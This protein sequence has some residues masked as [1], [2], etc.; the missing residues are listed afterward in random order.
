MKTYLPA[1][2][3]VI[4]NLTSLA[5]N[6]S[7]VNIKCEWLSPSNNSPTSFKFYQGTPAII[8]AKRS[9][10]KLFL[11]GKQNK[12]TKIIQ[13]GNGT[14]KDRAF[15]LT[16]PSSG[17]QFHSPAIPGDTEIII[18]YLHNNQK[19]QTKIFCVVPYIAK[20][21]KLSSDI[22]TVQGFALGFYPNYKTSKVS[23]IRNNPLHYTA[24]KL[25]V[26]ITPKNQDCFISPSMQMKNMVI[27]GDND[28]KRHTDFFPANM[29]FIQEI[30]NMFALFQ[31]QGLPMNGLKI[32]SAFRTPE[33]NSRIGS[34]KFSQH[35]YG[36]AIDIIFD[37]NN[38]GTADDL[39]GDGRVT[40]SDA[41][42]VVNAIE[43]AQ[44]RGVLA[45]GGIGV[46]YFDK[47]ANKHRLTFHVD[48]RGVRAFWAY[49]HRANGK[50]EEIKWNSKFFKNDRK[51][52]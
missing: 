52:K 26:E 33:Y 11:I 10:I 17:I 51:Q 13:R 36:D 28:N 25:Y 7:E 29:F 49:Y 16:T 2:F 35:I 44:S 34:S 43:E 21:S 37:A 32:I 42:I 27:I 40:L 6:A 9:I 23:K 4:L 1:L 45:L 22:I 20:Q 38:D 39:D 12:I 30:E 24:K 31:R 18:N 8:C 14:T 3:V 5:I 41:K 48:F 46:Y 50:I 15:L 47:R 19:K